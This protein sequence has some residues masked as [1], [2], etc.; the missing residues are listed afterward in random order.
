MLFATCVYLWMIDLNHISA[1]DHLICQ[2]RTLK[3]E[4][5]VCFMEPR[6]KLITMRK[7]QAFVGGRSVKFNGF[8]FY[9]MNCKKC[10]SSQ[11]K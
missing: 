1:I 4:I 10:D 6:P 8:L 11:K 5:L 2:N 3:N 9:I 7:I